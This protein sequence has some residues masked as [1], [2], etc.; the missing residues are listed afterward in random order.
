MCRNR[1]TPARYGCAF[2]SCSAPRLTKCRRKYIERRGFAWTISEVLAMARYIHPSTNRRLMR[3]R[4]A[5]AMLA[6]L[7][8]VLMTTLSIAMYTLAT[9]NSQTAYN[10]SDVVRAQTAAEAGLRWMTYRF[11]HI[12]R[13]KTTKGT[14]DTATAIALWQ[15]STGLQQKLIDDLQTL[16]NPLERPTVPA[17]RG[18]S[19]VSSSWIS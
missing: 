10:L 2:A 12:A 14:I 19:S 8:L 17:S 13:P 1:L 9:T 4:G 18:G 15:G 11:N 5:A 7:F 6:M 3:R 16:T